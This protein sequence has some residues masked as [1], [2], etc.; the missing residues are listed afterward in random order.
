MRW[1]GA[2]PRRKRSANC[3]ICSTNMKGAGDEH[4]DE[5]AS[6]QCN[7]VFGMGSVA[8]SLAGNCSC[9]R[10]CGG[11]GLV[12]SRV[13]ALLGRGCCAGVDA[14]GSACDRVLLFAMTIH[15]GI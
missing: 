15:Y 4:F 10:G 9:G 11:D 8:F 7:A 1:P 3:A 12:P 6:P 2:S 5:L 14:R 13:R